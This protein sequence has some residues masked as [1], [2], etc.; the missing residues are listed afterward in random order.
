MCIIF[1]SKKNQK[2][3]VPSI[4]ISPKG[5]I[6]YQNPESEK[7]QKYTSSIQTKID[8][9]QIK[10]IEILPRNFH[11]LAMG[12]FSEKFVPNGW[13]K[14]SKV[15]SHISVIFE[16]SAPPVRPNTG[17]KKIQIRYKIGKILKAF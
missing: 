10:P 1:F 3:L 13:V 5:W 2:G 7:R 12:L 11:S 4:K 16:E 6:F 17:N 8:V 14:F 15:W 9:N